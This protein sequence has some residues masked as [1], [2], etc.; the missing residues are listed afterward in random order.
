MA[1]LTR[2]D[3]QSVLESW[4]SKS[5]GGCKPT[6]SDQ[7]QLAS[8]RRRDE[9]EIPQK[10]AK[11]GIGS[12]LEAPITEDNQACLQE[13]QASQA[14]PLAVS[15]KAT[16]DPVLIDAQ[17]ALNMLMEEPDLSPESDRG[18]FQNRIAKL[19]KNVSQDSP[20][21]IPSD[22]PVYHV[23]RDEGL[24]HSDAGP[25]IDFDF[26]HLQEVTAL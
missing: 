8:K 22:T 12:H 9:Q 7:G 26:G 13:H 15:P 20:P 16:K 1:K 25:Y 10:R 5:S 17:A 19:A 23:E 6:D 24:R 14:G 3:I 2:R 21:R 4:D 18:K 11:Q